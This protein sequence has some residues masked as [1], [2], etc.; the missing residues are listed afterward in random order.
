MKKITKTMT[1]G[2]V[3]EINKDAKAILSGFGMHCFSCPM[4][5]METIEEAAMVH[6]VDAD[7]MLEKLNEKKEVK[8]CGKIKIDKN[9]K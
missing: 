7:L 1:I 2:E 3:L 4:S 5:Q 6:G 9:K 8:R